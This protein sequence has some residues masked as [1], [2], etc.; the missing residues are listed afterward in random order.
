M[1]DIEL[2]NILIASTGI[3]G[4]ILLMKHMLQTI[5]KGS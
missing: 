5:K 1:P 3:L 2:I 4:I